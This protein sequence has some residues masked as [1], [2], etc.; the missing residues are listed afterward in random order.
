VLALQE[1]GGLKLDDSISKYFDNIPEDKQDITIH[2]LLI[3]SSGITELANAG[4]WDPIYRK[5]FIER[6]MAQELAFEPG[7][8]YEYSNAGYSLL[9]AIIEHVTGSSYEQFIRQRLFLPSGMFQT[10]YQLAPWG[11]RQLA[12]GYR[13]GEK[14]GTVLERPMA[15][16]GP[17][18]V[19]RANGGIHSTAWDMVRWG[20]AL[21]AGNVLSPESMGLYWTPHVDE[22]FGDSHYA[23]GWV[24]MESGGQR[25]ITH[26]GGNGIVFADM[27]ILPEAGL[28]IVIQTNVVADF[29]LANQLLEQIRNRLILAEN[30]PKVPNRSVGDSSRFKGFVGKYRLRGGG[31]FSATINEGELILVPGDAHAFSA[32]LSTH[33]LDRERADRFVAKIDN[34]VSGYLAGDWA[35]LWEAYRRALPLE[36]LVERGD[37]RLQSLEQKFGSI[38]GH[39]VLGTAFR[40]GRDV[41][42]VRL[43]FEHGEEYR[44]Y[45][46][47]PDE[48]EK[49][50]GVS[51]RGLDH[52]VHVIPEGGAAF[53]TWDIRS[54]ASLPVRF[55]SRPG[56][57]VRMIYGEG[58]FVAERSD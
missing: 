18:W 50:L 54:G 11:E 46:W 44:A 12:Q 19:L 23:Y 2:Q 34:I 10:G 36:A 4:D 8:S 6:S 47:D 33:P 5:D 20:H 49:L 30:L 3:H 58:G 13:A 42:L 39:E 35:P 57:A 1:Q 26:N 29:G 32:L 40:D 17:F 14:W 51:G 43:S 53:A 22:G 9:G 7:T 15:E 16:D 25:V 52:R 27:A 45:V 48:E 28:V 31:T 37:E 56:E 55:E 38:K 21:M 41:T 24:V